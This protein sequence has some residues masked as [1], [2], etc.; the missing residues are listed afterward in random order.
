M[1]A[2]ILAAGRGKRLKDITGSS[3][4]CMFELVGKPV[5]EYNLDRAVELDLNELILVV[6]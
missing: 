4:K 2:L 6:G 5:L 3:N 1:K